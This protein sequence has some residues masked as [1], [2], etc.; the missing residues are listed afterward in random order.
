M[1][2]QPVTDFL[3]QLGSAAPTP[4]GGSVA[5]LTGAQAAALV[6][7]V[8]HLTIGKKRYAEHEDDLRAVLAQAEA[9]QAELTELVAADMAAYEQLSGAYKIP[10]DDPARADALAAALVPATEVPL[11]IAEASA[12][13]LELVP[14]VVEKGSVVAVSDAGMAALLA[15]A[16]VRSGALNVLINLGAYQDDEATAGYRARLNKVLGEPLSQA[17]ALYADVVKR[18]G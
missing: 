17:D 1:L 13:V 12:R 4:G 16:A 9:L 18:I 2:D 11:A 8:C 6:A 15:A 7:M 5:A 3:A 10:R 14:T